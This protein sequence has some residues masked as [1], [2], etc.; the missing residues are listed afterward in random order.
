MISNVGPGEEVSTIAFGFTA[1]NYH[2]KNSRFCYGH[3]GTHTTSGP[4]FLEG[5]P[6]SKA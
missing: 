2:D 4:S 1:K 6:F 5:I 3:D